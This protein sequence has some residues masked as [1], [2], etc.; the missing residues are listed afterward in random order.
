MYRIEPY[1]HAYQE[2]CVSLYIATWQEAPYRERFTPDEVNESLTRDEGFV[3]VLIDDRND[4][5]GFVSGRPLARDCEFFDDG[6]VP[7]VNRDV[8]FYIDAL[9][10]DKAR[11]ESGFGVTL[12]HF[13]MSVAR[14]AQFSQFVLRTHASASNPATPLYERLGFERRRTTGGRGQDHGVD[15]RQTRIDRDT[16]ETDFRFYYYKTIPPR[17]S[18][19]K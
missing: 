5:I 2:Q 12:M 4:V 19:Y 11:R 16:P 6:C 8:A 9:G 1:S 10:I 15:T 18:S 13:L 14:D 7:P 17:A 3:Y